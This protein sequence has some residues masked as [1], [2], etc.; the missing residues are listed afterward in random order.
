M[1]ISIITLATIYTV[2]LLVK[3]QY[4]KQSTKAESLNNYLLFKYIFSIDF[5]KA[6]SVSSTAEDQTLLLYDDSDIVS[7]NFSGKAVIRQLNNSTD[8]FYLFPNNVNIGVIENS[9]LINKVSFNIVPYSDTI[10]LVFQ[11]HYDAVSL[12]KIKVK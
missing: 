6:D 2:Y 8:S 10:L 4:V 12:I 3:N 11:K 7:Y 5:N 9:D 1:I